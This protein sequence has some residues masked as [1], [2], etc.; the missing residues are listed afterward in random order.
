MRI[1]TTGW[2][3]MGQ[4]GA[5]SADAAA[6]EGRPTTAAA[7]ALTGEATSVANHGAGVHFRK[8][9]GHTNM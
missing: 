6:A 9:P 1:A 5:A 7:A 4:I 8:E 2:G 3:P